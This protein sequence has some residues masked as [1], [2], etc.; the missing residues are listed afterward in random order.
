MLVVLVIKK[1]STLNVLCERSPLKGKR[2]KNSPLRRLGPS[3]G[4]AMHS[5]RRSGQPSAPPA[6][7]RWHRGHFA[8][9]VDAWI[10]SE[11]RPVFP[12]GTAGA[13]E[14]TE[15]DGWCRFKLTACLSLSI[16]L[17]KH[18]SWPVDS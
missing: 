7:G 17:W 2:C 10:D 13:L 9:E 16:P 15:Q 1:S 3:L 14:Y 11:A 18:L 5:C 4:C 6:Q 8:K 12:R